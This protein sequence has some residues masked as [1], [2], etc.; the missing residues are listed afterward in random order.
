MPLFRSKAEQKLVE[1]GLDPARLPEYL[2]RAL[3]ARGP[4]P[5]A[6]VRAGL[7]ADTVL[8][9][10]IAPYDRDVAGDLFAPVARRVPEFVS[11]RGT[12]GSSVRSNGRS[13]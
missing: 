5:R 1:R 12:S 4:R 11:R 2:W 13:G 3:A 9:M 8:A 6:D 10:L 7:V